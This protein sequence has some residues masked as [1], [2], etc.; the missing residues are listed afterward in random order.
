VRPMVEGTAVGGERRRRTMESKME[1]AIAM[2]AFCF[3]PL[4]T[5]LREWNAC[6]CLWV[7][8]VAAMSDPPVTKLGF[9]AVHLQVVNANV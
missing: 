2:A 7:M 5:A 8:Y 9:Y 1:R 4:Q 6:A 3:T